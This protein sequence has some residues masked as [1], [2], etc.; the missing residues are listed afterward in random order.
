MHIAKISRLVRNRRR[1][2]II[3]SN[4]RKIKGGRANG[5]QRNNERKD[6]PS[7]R[8][9]AAPHAEA[10]AKNRQGTGSGLRRSQR[11][12]CGAFRDTTSGFETDRPGATRL[13]SLSVHYLLA[14][15]PVLSSVPLI[16]SNLYSKISIIFQTIVELV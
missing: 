14:R 13:I 16:L 6:S 10:G 4:S 3:G 2:V 12:V 11:L 8:S 5:A 9:R 1:T 15:C 7:C